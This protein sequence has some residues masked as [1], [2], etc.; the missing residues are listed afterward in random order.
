VVN[1]QWDAVTRRERIVLEEKEYP[2]LQ[3]L[4]AVLVPRAGQNAEYRA[5]IRASRDAPNRVVQQVMNACSQ[6]GIAN[7]SLTAMNR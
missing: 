5:V 4:T 1:I 3:A 7:I 6:A 2:D